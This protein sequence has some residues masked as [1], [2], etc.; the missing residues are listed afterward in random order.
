MNTRAAIASATA[1]S[2]QPQQQPHPAG[3]PA[4]VAPTRPQRGQTPSPDCIRAPQ[5]SQFRALAA[6]SRPSRYAPTHSLLIGCPDA[7]FRG[8]PGAL[9]NQFDRVGR[10]AGAASEHLCLGLP[11]VD[12]SCSSISGGPAQRSRDEEHRHR[13]CMPQQRTKLSMRPWFRVIHERRISSAPIC[14]DRGNCQEKQPE[15]ALV[16]R[17][18][19]SEEQRERRNEHRDRWARGAF[20]CLA[21][22]SRAAAT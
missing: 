3:R 5:P 9:P 15:T 8:M 11:R 20:H 19:E 10:G 13:K 17:Q 1:T 4:A 14:P 18:D 12:P 2:Q 7:A 16:Q 6:A 21:R 22:S